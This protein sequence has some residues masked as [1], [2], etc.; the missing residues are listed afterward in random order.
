MIGQQWTS[1]DDP[2]KRFLQSQE[3]AKLRIQNGKGL[4]DYMG[5]GGESSLLELL[6]GNLKRE[7]EE[8]KKRNL[9]EKQDPEEDQG[10]EKQEV[11][12]AEEEKW[13]SEEGGRKKRKW[14][15]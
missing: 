11:E 12:K 2:K 14:R 8:R 5:R 4:E 10:Q 7:K 9:E 6:L 3:L 13:K 15:V 1:F